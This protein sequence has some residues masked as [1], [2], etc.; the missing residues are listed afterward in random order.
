MFYVVT[1]QRFTEGKALKSEAIPNPVAF[2]SSKV[3]T[4]GENPRNQVWKPYPYM[5]YFYLSRW[6]VNQGRKRAGNQTTN[7]PDALQMC[8]DIAE[9]NPLLKFSGFHVPN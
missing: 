5:Q 9:L 4:N 8:S 1:F 3:Q 6:D 2:P 7:Q